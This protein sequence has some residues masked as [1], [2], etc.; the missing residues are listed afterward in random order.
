MLKA[1]GRRDDLVQDAS[2]QRPA[3]FEHVQAQCA[4]TARE[5]AA[6]QH[7]VLN[8]DSSCVKLVFELEYDATCS[9]RRQKTAGESA[10]A[11]DA[12]WD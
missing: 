8:C 4:S 10:G 5:H 2:T 7:L 1:E 3:G 12:G 9:G 6:L 11:C